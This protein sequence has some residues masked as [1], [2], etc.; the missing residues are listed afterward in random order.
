M[1]KEYRLKT[2]PFELE[3]LIDDINEARSFTWAVTTEGP[4]EEDHE[5]C[6]IFTD[7]ITLQDRQHKARSFEMKDTEWNDPSGVMVIRKSSWYLC[8]YC[9]ERFIVND[10]AEELRRLL[11]QDRTDS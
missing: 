3:W 2:I 4:V 8:W 7:M 9:Y 11:H 6:L 1:S 5:H 10:G